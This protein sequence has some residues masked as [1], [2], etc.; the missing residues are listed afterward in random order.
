MKK[1][2]LAFATVLVFGSASTGFAG[3]GEGSPDLAVPSKAEYY[4]Q[5][6]VAPV[7]AGPRTIAP[8]A[9][10]TSRQG[11]TQNATVPTF[12]A[13]EKAWFDRASRPYGG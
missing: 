6:S 11:P 3:A 1:L 9:A 10:R 12:D 4:G 7:Y 5:T 8:V 13:A 2:A